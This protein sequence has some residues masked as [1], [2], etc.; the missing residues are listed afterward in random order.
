MSDD[1]AA[2][3]DMIVEGDLKVGERLHESRHVHRVMRE[4]A[5]HLHH[6]VSP[7][8]NGASHPVHV[9]SSQTPLSRPMD[10]EQAIPAVLY[11]QLLSNRT[12]AVRRVVICYEDPQARQPQLEQRSDDHREVG[13]LI[14]GRKYNGHRR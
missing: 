10:Y 8:A 2:M 9:C 14:V 1:G 6:E 13:G 12:C 5:V 11:C 4:I 3:R 7:S